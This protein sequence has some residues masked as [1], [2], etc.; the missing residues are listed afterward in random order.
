L[1]LVIVAAT[2][3]CR[4]PNMKFLSTQTLFTTVSDDFGFKVRVGY[5][6]YPLYRLCYKRISFH[7]IVRC[8][9]PRSTVDIKMTIQSRRESRLLVIFGGFID[10]RIQE[11]GTFLNCF[12]RLKLLGPFET[13]ITIHQW[14]RRCVN[15]KSCKFIM[16]LLYATLTNFP[17]Y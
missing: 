11:K 15:F 12:T 13:S 5:L 10:G 9:L 1:F 7:V 14:T 4:N 3:S 8:S 6:T 16:N 17:T 2:V